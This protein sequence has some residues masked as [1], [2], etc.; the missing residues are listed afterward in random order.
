[1]SV[2]IDSIGLRL[3]F[4]TNADE[5][6]VEPKSI[7]PSL[8]NRCALLEPADYSQTMLMPSLADCL[9]SNRCLL[10]AAELDCRSQG[11][12]RILVGASAAQR[13]DV[14]RHLLQTLVETN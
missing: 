7:E 2:S 10:L 1:M 14:F 9:S 13:D 11:R 8:K 3:I 12:G 6:A 4:A 5:P